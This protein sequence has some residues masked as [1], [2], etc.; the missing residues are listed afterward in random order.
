V[1]PFGAR[2]PIGRVVTYRLKTA[3]TKAAINNNPRGN[4]C[5]QYLR[6]LQCVVRFD[7]STTGH[8][9]EQGA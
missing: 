9:A 2:T 6:H 8:S 1:Q 3:T 5:E 7:P 4:D